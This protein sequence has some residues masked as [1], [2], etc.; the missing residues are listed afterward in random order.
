MD[1]ECGVPPAGD[2]LGYV[3]EINKVTELKRI[4]EGYEGGEEKHL[5]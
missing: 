1:E 3:G 4:I 5:K 2:S